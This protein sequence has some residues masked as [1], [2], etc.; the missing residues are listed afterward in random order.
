MVVIMMM[1]LVYMGYYGYGLSVVGFVI[2]FYVGVMYFL[3]FVIGM[4]IDKIG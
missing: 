3:F 2:G 1:I 4:L